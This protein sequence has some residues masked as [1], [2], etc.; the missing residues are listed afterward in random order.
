MANI[1]S[2]KGIGHHNSNVGNLN[3]FG[4]HWLSWKKKKNKQTQTNTFFCIWV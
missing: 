4:Y 3:C 2:F 1:W